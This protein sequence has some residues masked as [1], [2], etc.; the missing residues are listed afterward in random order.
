L[1]ACLTFFTQGFV[2]EGP[3]GPEG[4]PGPSLTGS[5]IGFCQLTDAANNL[6]DDRSGVEV[7]VEGTNVSTTTSSDGRYTLTGVPSGIHVLRYSKQGF[8]VWKNTQFQYVGGG[9]YYLGYTYLYMKPLFTVTNLSATTSAGSINILGTLSGTLP[10]STRYAMLFFDTTASVSSDPSHYL[11]AISVYI[12]NTSS[13]L[14][15]I[16]SSYE[17]ERYGVHSGD[18]L[19]FAAYGAT[20][21]YSSYIDL[22]TLKYVYPFVSDVASNT[23]SVVV[24]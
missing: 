9:D 7:S 4:P 6:I 12:P 13:T 14:L 20:N 8:G 17:W 11:F 3:Q 10:T 21:S 23:V 15:Y 5:I 2:C 19:Y 22:K 1:L 24:P 18:V 16:A